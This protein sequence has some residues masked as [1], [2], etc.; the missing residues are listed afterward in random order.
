MAGTSARVDAAEDALMQAWTLYAV[1]AIEPHSVAVMYAL[2]DHGRGSP[3]ATKA[4][5]AACDAMKR[6]LAVLDKALAGGSL[7]GGRFTVADINLAEV[8]RYAQSETA[9]FAAHPAVDAWLKACQARP[10]FKAMWARRMA[11]PE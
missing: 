5:D 8:L 4:I 9:F 11:E 7:V 10:A 3:A 6:P 1:S 2:R